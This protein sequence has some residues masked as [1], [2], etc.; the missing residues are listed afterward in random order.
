[1]GLHSKNASAQ[2]LQRSLLEP[3]STFLWVS[4]KPADGSLPFPLTGEKQGRENALLNG[5]PPPCW[6][7]AGKQCHL[8]SDQSALRS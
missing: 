4:W 2:R 1:M 6:E 3:V 8:L 7:E 5:G